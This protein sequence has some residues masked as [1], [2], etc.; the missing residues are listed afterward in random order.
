MNRHRV[1][2][3]APRIGEAGGIYLMTWQDLRHQVRCVMQAGTTLG[4]RRD[5]VEA[6]YRAHPAWRGD[7]R[8]LRAVSLATTA[9]LNAL[10]KTLSEE[11]YRQHARDCC[12]RRCAPVCAEASPVNL[13]QDERSAIDPPCSTIETYRIA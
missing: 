9:A 7:D 2:R 5:A 10:K 11:D 4:Q 12:V 6:V 8:P 13:C 1:A 3:R